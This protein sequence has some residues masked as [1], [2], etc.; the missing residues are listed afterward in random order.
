[1]TPTKGLHEWG[2]KLCP[3]LAPWTMVSMSILKLSD[4]CGQGHRQAAQAMEVREWTVTRTVPSGREKAGQ[5]PGG[6]NSLF[7]GTPGIPR[8][9]RDSVGC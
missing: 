7:P 1:M 6:A 5:L 3:I 8:I 9:C 4:H 2:E